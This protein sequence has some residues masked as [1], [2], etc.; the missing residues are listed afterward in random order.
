MPG[1]QRN[2]KDF[3]NQRHDCN[4]KFIEILGFNPLKLIMKNSKVDEESKRFRNPLNKRIIYEKRK[5][6]EELI[7]KGM[8]A[9]ASSSNC[10]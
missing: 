6:Y 1:R 7:V 10:S 2:K 9:S 5:I 3:Y 4:R 8:R